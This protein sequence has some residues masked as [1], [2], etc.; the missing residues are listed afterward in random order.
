MSLEQPPHRAY[1]NT[2]FIVDRE[3]S[4]A[5]TYLPRESTASFSKLLIPGGGAASL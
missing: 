3:Q 4:I 1:S 2:W 5:P